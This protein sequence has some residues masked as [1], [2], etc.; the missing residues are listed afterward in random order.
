MIFE[1]QDYQQ[2]CITNI[3]TLLDGFDFKCQN[4]SNLQSCLKTFH[5]KSTIPIKTL[6]GKLNI[7]ILMDI[8]TGKNFHLPKS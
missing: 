5:A 3:I 6:S 1:K 7:D 2:E 4:A 8:G